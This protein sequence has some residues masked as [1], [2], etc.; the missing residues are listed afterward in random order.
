MVY[1]TMTDDKQQKIKHN[2]IFK[3]E[4]DSSNFLLWK[5]F[6]HDI[7]FRKNM[8]KEGYEQSKKMLEQLE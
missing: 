1:N 7:E 6:A 3:T 4:H 5:C 8:I 2:F